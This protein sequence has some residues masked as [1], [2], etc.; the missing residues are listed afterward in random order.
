MPPVTRPI[1]SAAP[2]PVLETQVF[3]VQYRTQLLLAIAALLSAL[4]LYGGY[5][6]YLSQRDDSAAALLASAKNATDYQKVISDYPG[7]PSAASAFLLLADAQ[8]KEQKLVDANATLKNFVDKNPKHELVTTAK[9]AMAG[10][11][12]SLGKADEALE[13][14]KRIAAEYPRNFNA[15]FALLAQVHL[16]KQKGQND[17]ARRICET[18]LTQYRDSYAATEASRYLRLLKPAA[19]AAVTAP[20]QT[21]VAPPPAVQSSPAVSATPQG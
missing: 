11:L 3:W 7:A 6:F 19:A 13:T 12:E 18:V 5:R 14:Y 20:P 4:A 21:S 15:P 17:E 2:D 10:N 8:R 16:L 9:M 1:S